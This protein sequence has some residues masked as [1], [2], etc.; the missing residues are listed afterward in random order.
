MSREIPLNCDS[1]RIE[2]GMAIA[3]GGRGGASGRSQQDSRAGADQLGIGVPNLFLGPRIE[4]A[5]KADER[6]R[7]HSGHEQR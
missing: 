1:R 6:S 3:S 2:S 7:S 5:G 4:R